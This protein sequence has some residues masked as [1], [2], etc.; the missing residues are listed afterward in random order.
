MNL[1]NLQFS[2]AKA[3]SQPTHCLA[4]IQ[5]TD[6]QTLK[7]AWS[8]KPSGKTD[9]ILPS[10]TIDDTSIN[11]S[12]P[13]RATS[14][15]MVGAPADRQSA[16][17]PHN[18]FDSFSNTLKNGGVAGAGVM[19]DI[20]LTIIPY[21]GEDVPPPRAIRFTDALSDGRTPPPWPSGGDD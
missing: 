21:N 14:E 10:I 20:A 12:P 5:N 18:A 15:L 7:N 9:H 8:F 1:E 19:D 6:V 2:D 3:V 17:L 16:I 13:A 4:D 11:F